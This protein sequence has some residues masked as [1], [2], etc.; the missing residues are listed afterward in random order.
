MSAIVQAQFLHRVH[1]N[2]LNLHLADG[3]RL[4]AEP[5]G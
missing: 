3:L 4:R 2:L 5:L 1:D